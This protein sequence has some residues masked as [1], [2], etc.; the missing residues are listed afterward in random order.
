[1]KA[2]L[3]GLTFRGRAFLGAGVAAVVCGI[4]LDQRG[5]IRIGV[6]AI[7][8]P[9]VVAWVIGRGR[10]RLSLR[11]TVAPEVV[12]AG[13]IARVQLTV[14]NDGLMP[15]GAL[16]LE[17]TLPYQ[18]GSRPRFVIDRMRR[19]WGHTVDY[20]LRSDVR[21]S[22][23]I[24]PMSVRLADPFGLVELDRTFT[25]TSR[26]LVTPRVEP[27]TPVALPGGQSTSGDARPRAFATG[28]AEDVTVREY[29][30]GDDLRRV[31]WRSSARIGE[32]MV[33]RE[34]Q[35]WQARATILLDDRACAHRGAG[36][37]SSF[38]AAV[39]AAASLV[40]HL[41]QRGYAVRLAT[42]SG[43]VT[44]D[45]AAIDRRAVIATM[46]ERLAAAELTD[47]VVIDPAWL[48]DSD[49][50]GLTVAVL[51]AVGEADLTALRR[52]LHH[53]GT[54]WAI[55]LDVAAWGTG[56]A[57]LPGSAVAGGGWK[58]AVLGPRDRIDDAWRQF[59]TGGR[60]Y[61]Q[62]GVSA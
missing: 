51:G 55:A 5:L 59:G 45:S 43:S 32:L 29:R 18:L 54:G 48:R 36:A 10:Y 47:G 27:L 19:G 2:A 26:L 4:V 3:R 15:T 12:A 33:R 31:H 56:P 11:R 16:L 1:M 41:E 9:L 28:S 44:L 46:M 57:A 34:E 25:T 6:L 60:R 30:R 62:T 42:A 50:G 23:A 37:A 53:A 35:P 24:G 49:S 8:L 22:F 17:E 40:S 21:G 52:V 20:Q 7:A 13:Q 14:G 39:T 58:A 38:E 61:G